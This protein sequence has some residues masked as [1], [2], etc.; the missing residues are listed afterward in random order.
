MGFFVW[1]LGP[2]LF[3]IISFPLLM[4]GGILLLAFFLVIGPIAILK[5][6]IWLKT[7][8]KMLSAGVFFIIISVI[9]MKAS[10]FL[11]GLWY[12]I[13]FTGLFACAAA[14]ADIIEKR[15]EM[16]ARRII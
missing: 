15:E 16:R 2:G 4:L 12:F 1:L 10:P 8:R 9:F 7:W 5:F 14:I 13:M 11:G 3:S 6:S